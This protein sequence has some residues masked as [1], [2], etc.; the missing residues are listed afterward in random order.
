MKTRD[1]IVKEKILIAHKHVFILYKTD[2]WHRNQE[3]LGVFRTISDAMEGIKEVVIQEGENL[4]DDDLY[5]LD[6]IRQT[7]GYSGFGEF[8]V[9]EVELNKIL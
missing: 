4:S 9:E 1:E 7:Q 8:V 6:T 2:A 5:N 3:I